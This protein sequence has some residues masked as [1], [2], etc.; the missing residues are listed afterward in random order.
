[1]RHHETIRVPS[2]VSYATPKPLKIEAI[3]ASKIEAEVGVLV[4]QLG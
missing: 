1:M 3:Q 4:T 2:V